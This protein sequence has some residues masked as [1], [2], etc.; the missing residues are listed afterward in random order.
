MHTSV[1]PDIQARFTVLYCLT[2]LIS[3][4]LV[5]VYVICNNYLTFLLS[6]MWLLYSV[7]CVCQVVCLSILA[8]IRTFVNPLIKPSVHSGGSRIPETGGERSG[9]RGGER[10]ANWTTQECGPLQISELSPTVAILLVLG[11]WLTE[12]HGHEQRASQIYC[13]QTFWRWDASH[14]PYTFGNLIHI[15]KSVSTDSIVSSNVCPRLDPP[16]VQA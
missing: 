9:E 5:S 1:Y 6:L 8:T 7:H 12:F 3:S 14:T 16:P 2:C 11:V 4:L 10:G 13:N 15:A